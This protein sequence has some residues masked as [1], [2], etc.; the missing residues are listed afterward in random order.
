MDFSL[1]ED[2][3]ALRE[4]ARKILE[5][6]AGHERLKQIEASEERV[7]RALWAALARA[8]LLGVALPEAAGGSGLGLLEACLVLEEVGRAVAPVPA[9]ATLVLGA[10]PLAAF[11]TP[12]QRQAWLPGVAAG[13]VMLSAALPEGGAPEVEARREGGGFRL[14]GAC[15]FV[16][17]AHVAARVLVPAR[18][19]E[20]A[21]G[22][23]LVDPAGPGA[24]LERVEWVHGQIHPTLRLDG[25]RV[26][27]SDALG[28][29]DAGAAVVA[30]L[31][32]RALLSLCA[33]QLGVASR[34]LEMTASYTTE[35][36]QFDR[37]IGSFQAVHQ[38]A[39]DAYVDLQ[40]MRLTFWRA[41]H[42]LERGAAAA[43]ELAVAKYWAAQGGA[44]VTYAAQHLHGGIGVD[45]DYPLHRYFLWAAHLG[46]HLGGPHAQ[47]AE[48][49]ARMA[50][51]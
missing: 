43:E 35:R 1:S 15:R 47:L 10:L 38:R 29:P 7:D 12:A 25:A 48:L 37:P 21:L 2:Q 24:A 30:W 9:H 51:D 49:G 8:N 31:R 19:G 16:P 28:A 14:D 39:A 36:R 50:G 27:E 46:M 3:Q 4:L 33:Q 22:V 5:T 32:D 40:A 6:E 26:A 20:R 23:F 13:E 42:L 44:R 45:V 34:A 17:A 41:L 11:G 18:T